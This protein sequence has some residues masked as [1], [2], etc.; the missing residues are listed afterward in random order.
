MVQSNIHKARYGLSPMAHSITLALSPLCIVQVPI[1]AIE[2]VSA[3]PVTTIA[4]IKI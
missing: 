1:P 2:T 4:T 3:L